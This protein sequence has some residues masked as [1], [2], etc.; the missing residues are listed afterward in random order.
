LRRNGASH[1]ATLGDHSLVER[2][3]AVTAGVLEGERQQRVEETGNPTCE[4]AEGESTCDP[5]VLQVRLAD[6]GRVFSEETPYSHACSLGKAPC[7]SV[8]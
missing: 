8:S 6:R 1:A 3:D 5:Q 2:F 7:D 4:H